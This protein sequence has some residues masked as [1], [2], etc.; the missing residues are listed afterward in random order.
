MRPTLDRGRHSGSLPRRGGLFPAAKALEKRRTAAYNGSLE[1]IARAQAAG[2]LREDFTSQ[3]LPVL[4]MANAGVVAATGDAVP[5]AWRRQLGHLLRGYATP[6]THVP[7]L[8]DAPA[9]RRPPLS[10]ARWF[11]SRALDQPTKR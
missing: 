5:D 1:L 11:A 7:P 3:D 10:T 8:P 2:H 6:G 9:P 4:L